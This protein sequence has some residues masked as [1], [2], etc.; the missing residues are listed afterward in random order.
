[1]SIEIDMKNLWSNPVESEWESFSRKLKKSGIKYYRVIYKEKSLKDN[2]GL[3][4][5]YV[6]LYSNTKKLVGNVPIFMM[7]NKELCGATIYLK[8]IKNANII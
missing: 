4:N 6:E 1:M 2:T 8:G 5:A 3:K 7:K